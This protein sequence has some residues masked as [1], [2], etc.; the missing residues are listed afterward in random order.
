[1]FIMLDDVFSAIKIQI[2]NNFKNSILEK[3][4]KNYWL[5]NLDKFMALLANIAHLYDE[6]KLTKMAVDKLYKHQIHGILALS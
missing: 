5:L 1:M 2:F 4:I 6:N 3:L